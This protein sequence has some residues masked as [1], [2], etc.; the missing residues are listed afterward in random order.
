MAQVLRRQLYSPGD[1]GQGS[2]DIYA[3]GATE[4]AHAHGEGGGKA[5]KITVPPYTGHMQGGGTREEVFGTRYVSS[6][7]SFTLCLTFAHR[8]YGSG[9][10]GEVGRGVV[11]RGFPFYFWPVVWRGSANGLDD[12]Y[13]YTTDVGP[14]SVFS[15]VQPFPPF[16]F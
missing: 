14:L 1:D 6:V 4:T 15:V 3:N 16:C 13:I 12:A 10:P 7:L 5:A 2:V 8:E 11:G 9:Y